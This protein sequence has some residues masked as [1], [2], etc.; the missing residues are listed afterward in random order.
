MKITFLGHASFLLTTSAGTRIV[1]DPFDPKAYPD[2]LLYRPFTENVDVVTSSHEH[3]DH[4]ATHLVGGSPIIIKGNGKFM[5]KE[6]EFLGVGTYHDDT[7]GTQRGKNTVFV[8][9]ADGLRIAHF[10]DLGHVLSSDQAA[11]IGAVDVALVPIGGFYTIDAAQAWKVAEQVSAQLV[12]PM[13][14]SNEK[15]LFP[16]AGVEDFIAGRPNV[17]REGVSTLEVGPRDVPDVMTAVVL[18]PS[19]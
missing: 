16:I 5:A 19:L 12:V 7:R 13:H 15:C 4:G 11:E 17:M 18:E 9:S 3:G 6:V 2:S 10:G 8:I 14:Y 1:T